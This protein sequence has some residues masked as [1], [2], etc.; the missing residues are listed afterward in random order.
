MGN[1]AEGRQRKGN[2]MATNTLTLNGPKA[3]T[4]RRNPRG[5]F[6]KHPGSGEWWIC[7]WDAQGRKRREKAGTKSNAI[8]LYRKRKN[9]AL[10]GKKL[11]EKLRRR[12]VSFAELCA[13]ALQHA[14]VN[15]RHVNETYRIQVLKEEF[16]SRGAESI[17]IAAFRSYF[18]LQDWKPG[19]FNRNRTTLFSVYRLGIENGKVQTNPAKL[20]KRKKVSDERVRF[21]NQ[22]DPLDTEVAYLKQLKTEEQRLRAV[23]EQEWPEHIEELEIALH[24]GMRRREQYERIDWSCVDLTRKD[25]HVPNSKN[26][27]GRHIPLNVE[28]RTAFERLRKARIGDGPIPIT[29]QGP[30]FIT[31]RGERLLGPR[32]WFED[33]VEKAGIK[34]FTWHDLRHTFAS[35]LVM[36]DVDIRTVAELMGHK[37]IQMTMRYAHLAPEHKLVAVER[38]ARYNS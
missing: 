18:D 13:D 3:P 25:L 29:P 8:D 38:L 35:R 34:D 21:I 33:A 11:P 36:A 30:V 5:V 20:L 9:E 2:A 23:I 31:K 28:A 14:K 16:G 15:G 24:T 22:F 7:Y 10:Q 4:A 19:T 6:E 27:E 1:S 12:I 26:G 37:S 32:H 17:P